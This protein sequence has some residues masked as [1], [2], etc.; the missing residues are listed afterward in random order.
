MTNTALLRL[1]LPLLLPIS[2]W[3]SDAASQGVPVG[4]YVQA[5]LAL[6]LIIGLLFGTAWL[7]RKL[8]GG[9]GFGQGG[10]KIIGGVAL[11]PRERVVLVEVGDTWLVIGIVPGQIRTLHRLPKGDTV[12]TVSP[13]SPDGA[14]FS[15]LLRSMKERQNHA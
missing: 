4:T 5:T 1:I 13:T 3:G 2:A 14:P 15:Q 6:A 10:M 12:E 7:A 8:A 9:K 11:G